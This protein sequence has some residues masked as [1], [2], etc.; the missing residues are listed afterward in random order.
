LHGIK[1]IIMKISTLNYYLFLVLFVFLASCS[2]STRIISEPPGAVVVVNGQAV[3]ETPY[4]YED[5]KISFSKTLITLE[6]EG[7]KDKN[8]V[9]RKDE[10]IDMGA[11][12]GGIFFQW[13]FIWTFGYQPEHYYELQAINSV[14]STD[15]SYTINE[16]DQLSKLNEMYKEGLIDQ[17]EFDQIKKRILAKEK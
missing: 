5:S 15:R 14:R 12:V 9:L 7:Y 6:K 1:V 17:E 11:I 13:P 16:L 4:V 8:I 2:S 3:G 10:E